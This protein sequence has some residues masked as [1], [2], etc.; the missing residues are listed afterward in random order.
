[1]TPE[2]Q[3]KNMINAG[4][5]FNINDKVTMVIRDAQIE[6]KDTAVFQLIG[7]SADLDACIVSSYC[8]NME[9][10]RRFGN[11]LIELADKYDPQAVEVV[12]TKTKK[13]KR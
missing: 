13:G 2:T 7:Y 8:A 3:I 10:A 4:K 6:G 5:L 9:D 11:Y 12:E 1:M